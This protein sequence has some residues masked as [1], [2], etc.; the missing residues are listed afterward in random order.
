MN[1]IFPDFIIVVGFP[2]INFLSLSSIK[3]YKLIIQ[4]GGK[5]HEK[6]ALLYAC[7]MELD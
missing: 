4:L 2:S 1:F 6:N 3:T 5:K 7:G